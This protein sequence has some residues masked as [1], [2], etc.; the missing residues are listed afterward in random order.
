MIV[1]SNGEHRALECCR[2]ASVEELADGIASTDPFGQ[3]A[4][5]DLQDIERSA[6]R[7]AVVLI[8]HA[9]ARYE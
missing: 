4:L 6:P 7:P 9:G 1:P 8:D 2:Q 3:D 5:V